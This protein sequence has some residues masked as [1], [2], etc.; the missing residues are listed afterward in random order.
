MIISILQVR[1]L[2]IGISVALAFSCSDAAFAQTKTLDQLPFAKLVKLAKAGDSEAGFVLAKLFE[3]GSRGVELNYFEAAKWYRVAALNGHLESQFRLA[4]LL[5]VGASKLPQDKPTSLTL[6]EDAAK[7]GHAP[8]IYVLGT[9]YQTGDGVAKDPVRAR[10]NYEE[11][12]TRKHAP[13]Y[14]SLGLLYLKGQGVVADANKAKAYF[15]QAVAANDAWGC[16]NLAVMYEQGWGTPRDIAQARNYYQQAVGLGLDVAA[17]NL[18]RLKAITSSTT[19]A[20]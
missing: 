1:R 15:E 3:D 7:R 20:P 12:A 4:K 17:K 8:S 2:A 13:A 9:I 10:V 18:E 16:N 19:P 5:R 14:N 6:L 11:A